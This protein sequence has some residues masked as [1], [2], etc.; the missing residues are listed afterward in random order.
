[1]S[2]GLA[3]LDQNKKPATGTQSPEPKPVAEP[4]LLNVKEV[5]LKAIEVG[6]HALVTGGV[7]N[8]V[9]IANK[10][11]YVRQSVSQ[12]MLLAE[13]VEQEY[14]KY[15]GKFSQEKED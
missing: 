5:K 10:H 12:I 14:I 1:M 2:K 4:L 8:I 6:L 7:V 13:I 3:S 9:G 11:M 15:H